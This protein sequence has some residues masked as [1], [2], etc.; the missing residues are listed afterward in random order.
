MVD[1]TPTL[2][3]K[4]DQLN[5]DDLIGSP[6]SITITKVTQG[7]PEQPINI[8]YEGC[9][10]KPWRPC[11]SMR[12]ALVHIWGADGATYTG[13]SLSLYRDNGVKFGGME[14][15]G[16]R[17]SHASHIKS[18][19]QM[20]LMATKG[21]RSLFTIQPLRIQVD[22]ATDKSSGDIQP[23]ASISDRV[24]G[25]IAQIEAIA[26]IKALEQ[27]T[28]SD[29]YTGAVK[30]LVDGGHTEELYRLT[31][32]AIAKAEDL[33]SADDKWGATLADEDAA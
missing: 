32:S 18:A 17:I 33:S 22:P 24:T 31:S 11:K 3:A 1:L 26:D 21:K 15:G 25:M 29:R 13:K 8:Y 27:M 28:A 23:K 5:A 30:F 16:I 9:E 6:I 14:V 19:Q 10:N 4:S 20:A 7:N 12:R 2:V